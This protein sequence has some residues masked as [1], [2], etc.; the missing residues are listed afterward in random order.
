[1]SDEESAGPPPEFEPPSMP[2]PPLPD[3]IPMSSLSPPAEFDPSR[4]RSASVGP[5]GKICYVF[6]FLKWYCF[7]M[8]KCMLTKELRLKK[9][10][11]AVVHS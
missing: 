11:M 8:L 5:L 2:P 10:K 6:C 4:I 7:V 1:M 3:N 9:V